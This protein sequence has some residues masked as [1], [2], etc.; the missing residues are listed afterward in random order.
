MFINFFRQAG[1]INFLILPFILMMLWVFILPRN[2]LINSE[3]AFPLF[4]LSA[5]YLL[6]Y[7]EVMIGVAVTLILFQA[8]YLNYIINH[9]GVI[10]EQTHLP[11]LVYVV[12]MSSLPE[13]LSLSPMVFAN[14][15]ILM[16]FN[17]VL[18]FYHAEHAAMKAF[19]AGTFLGIAGL[20]YWPSVILF[21][22]LLSSLL[23]IRVFNWKEWVA[24]LAGLALPLFFLSLYFYLTDSFNWE[25][26][27]RLAEPFYKVQ[28]SAVY[29][30]SYIMVFV[31]L[32]VILIGSL[33]RFFSD[34]NTY[35]KL[36][37]RRYFQVL[38][39]FL[40]FS[41]L[42]YFISD[43]KS[44]IGLSFV[45]LPLSVFIANYFFTIRRLMIGELLFLLLL[46]SI[47]YNQVIHFGKQY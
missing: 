25:S 1:W 26:Y 18:H 43:K 32:T 21:G 3:N 9:H 14:L 41:L 36:K 38:I 40:L 33:I 27:E 39:W 46:I 44:M 20:F 30:Q 34:L 23:I 7:R 19:D 12:L 10:R 13:Q 17:S 5:K 45:A 37:N 29:I 6:D 8:Y 16:A 35:T 28:F 22:F 11:A 42:A 31:V 2:E 24:G 15:F 47:I 4:L